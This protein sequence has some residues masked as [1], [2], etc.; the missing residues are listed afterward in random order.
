VSVFVLNVS[1]LVSINQSPLEN[2]ISKDDISCISL[3]FSL[4]FTHAAMVHSCLI[5]LFKIGTSA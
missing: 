3:Q 5:S 4:D 1:T 2:G